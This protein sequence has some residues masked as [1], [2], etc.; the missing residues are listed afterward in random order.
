MLP[1]GRNLASSAESECTSSHQQEKSK[2]LLHHPDC[3]LAW[4]GLYT[5][6]K[7]PYAYY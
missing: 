7:Q 1:L 6:L 4:I 3:W 5:A 2:I